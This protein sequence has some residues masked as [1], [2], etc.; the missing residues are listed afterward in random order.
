MKTGF[1]LFKET[2]KER[3]GQSDEN[4]F[5]NLITWRVNQPSKLNPTWLRLF[6]SLQCKTVRLNLHSYCFRLQMSESRISAIARLGKTWEF[7]RCTRKRDE[8]FHFPNMV[9][10]SEILCATKQEVPIWLAFKLILNPQRKN[11][12]LEFLEACACLS[13]TPKMKKKLGCQY[14]LLSDL[15]PLEL[16]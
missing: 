8:K 11:K 4:T 10:I 6:T 1:V 13:R 16:G 3:K 14:V 5:A 15:H 2:E 7:R 9:Y 12:Y